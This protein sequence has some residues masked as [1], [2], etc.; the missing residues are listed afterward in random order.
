[1]V[2][3]TR[4]F[5]APP[6]PITWKQFP[7]SITCVQRLHMICTWHDGSAIVVLQHCNFYARTLFT[8]TRVWL[9][10]HKPFVKQ[11]PAYNIWLGFN[12]KMHSPSSTN[13]I[14]LSGWTDSS[15]ALHCALT[16]ECPSRQNCREATLLSPT[17]NHR[18]ALQ[19]D[20]HQGGS[21][22]KQYHYQQQPTNQG[23]GWYKFVYIYIY[24]HIYFFNRGL[25]DIVKVYFTTFH[26]YSYLRAA[27]AAVVTAV[28]YEC[29][30]W[31]V[32]NV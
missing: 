8:S 10:V 2:P 31:K 19:K 7:K 25:F 9:W 30:I 26:L 32:N 11:L 17:A 23:G 27:T 5:S 1:M 12:S 15:L 13:V 4:N 28:K 24:I 16:E 3:T 29:D 21:A 20:G 22:E 6:T 18:P 14:E